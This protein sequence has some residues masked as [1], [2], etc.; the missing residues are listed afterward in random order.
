MESLQVLVVDDEPLA[1]ARLRSLLGECKDPSAVVVGDACS[2][3]AALEIVHNLPTPVD[4]ALIDIHMPGISGMELAQMLRNSVTPPQLVFVT[5]YQEHAV[6]AFE[7]EAADYLSK[8]VRLE[9]LQT[10]LRKAARL[11]AI[12]RDLR[13]QPGTEYLTISERGRVVRVPLAEVL[14]L[15]AEFKYITVGTAHRQYLFDGS[16]NQLEEQYPDR[17]IRI[18]RNALVA[19]HA[20]RELVRRHDSPEGESWAVRLMSIDHP[21]MV[22]RRQIGSLKEALA[23]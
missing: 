3:N 7:L 5:A 20:I 6:Q 22:S 12:E 1:R 21:L 8:P 2:A 18:H 9:R 11:M 19:R 23:V 13:N 10:A 4:V 14:Y 15:K 17:F 16:L